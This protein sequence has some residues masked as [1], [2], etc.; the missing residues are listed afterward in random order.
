[1]V[2]PFIKMAII[3][4][5]NYEVSFGSWEKKNTTFGSQKDYFQT[6]GELALVGTTPK[7]LAFNN[8]WLL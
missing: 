2:K 4:S 5:L 1:M 3:V 7:L 6:V 8:C